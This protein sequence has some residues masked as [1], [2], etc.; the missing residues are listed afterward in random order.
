V[1]VA[2]RRALWSTVIAP[3]CSSMLPVFGTDTRSMAT[4]P[5]PLA[6]IAVPPVLWA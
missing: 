2:I 4:V 6:V 1:P 5:L 3:R